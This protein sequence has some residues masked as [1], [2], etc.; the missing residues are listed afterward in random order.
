MIVLIP[1]AIIFFCFAYLSLND[2]ITIIDKVVVTII[3]T[4]TLLLSAILYK[5]LKQ[6]IKQQKIN[7]IIIEI[8]QVQF[9]LANTKDEKQRLFL[10]KKLQKLQKEKNAKL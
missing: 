6:N 5:R 10:Q 8:N 4:T 1:I 3:I 7:Q 9:K 2:N